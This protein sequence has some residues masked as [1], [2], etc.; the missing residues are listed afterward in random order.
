MYIKIN[1]PRRGVAGTGLGWSGG[2]TLPGSATRYSTETCTGSAAT[3]MTGGNTICGMQNE[4]AYLNSI[5]C[6]AVGFRGEH[7][8]LTDAGNRGA[9][10]CCPPGVLQAELTGGAAP[11]A[12]PIVNAGV[13]SQDMQLLSLVGMLAAAGVIGYFVWKRNAAKQFES[14]KDLWD[15]ED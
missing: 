14:Q 15:L 7:D 13:V 3:P 1:K 5:G 10:Y 12:T 8:C 2:F 6:V 4:A 9:I 11:A